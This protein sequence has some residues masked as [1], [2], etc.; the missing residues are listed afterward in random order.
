M[1]RTKKTYCSAGEHPR[2][3][4]WRDSGAYTK[5]GY[6]HDVRCIEC[7]APLTCWQTVGSY[8]RRADFV[9]MSRRWNGLGPLSEAVKNKLDRF[10][11]PSRHWKLHKKQ[12]I[13]HA[14]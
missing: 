5:D 3:R 12:V 7:G 4:H 8:G 2:W 6:I 11:I 10:Q 1:N 14:R 13:A 9:T